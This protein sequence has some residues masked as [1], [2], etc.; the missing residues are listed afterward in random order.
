MWSSEN[1]GA[2]TQ[3]SSSCT[4]TSLIKS[5]STIKQQG[6]YVGQEAIKYICMNETKA[7]N[8]D[9]NG[10]LHVNHEAQELKYALDKKA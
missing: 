1:Q 10:V 9:E 2:S 4:Y 6:K 7:Y 5:I 3:G 8:R